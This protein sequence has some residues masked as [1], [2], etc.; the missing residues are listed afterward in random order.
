MHMESAPS[1][2]S[3]LGTADFDPVRHLD[4]L[5]A[6]TGLSVASAGG[7]VTFS[8]AD[9]IVASRLRLGACIGIPI[10]GGAVAAAALGKLRTGQG[11][12]LALDLRQAIHGI[13][14]IAF[15][16]PTINGETP[17]APLVAD[18]PFLLDSYRTRDGRTVMACAVYPHQVVT[19][20]RLLDVPPDRA[21]VAQAIAQWDAGSLE[22][23]ASEAGLPACV[24]RTAEEWAATEQGRWLAGQPVIALS[25]IGDAAPRVLPPAARPLDGVRVLSFTHAIS[26]PVVGRTLAEQ[27]ADV[28]CATRPNDFEHDF[29]YDEANVGSRSAYLDLTTERGR[30]AADSLL[31]DANVVVGNFRPGKIEALGL[32]PVDLARRYPGIIT[33]SVSCYGTGGPWASRGGFDMNGSAAAGLMAVEGTPEN[34]RLPITGLINDFITG[35]MGAIGATA[36][37]VRQATEGG[38]WQ[39]SVSLSRTAM[40][41]LTLG[42][43]DPAEAGTSEEHSLREPD[44]YDAPSPLGD[45]HMLAPPVRFSGTAPQWPVPPLV[46]RGSSTPTWACLQTLNGQ[47][48][49][50][51]MPETGPGSAAYEVNVTFRSWPGAAAAALPSRFP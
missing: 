49:V 6:D 31:A 34:P 13:M 33:V 17:P 51:A 22:D 20:C 48:R 5:L 2:A 19:W 3:A 27:G 1:V 41:Y 30:L 43:V 15:W 14:P 21:R 28:L 44:S 4:R 23:A 24:V 8:G 26:G 38:S 25:R 50:P 18:N 39:V 29:I 42:L 37:I 11:Q 36:A 35:Y 16:H 12:D 46:P 10:M 47:G 45:V 7:T 40:W 32:D 9:P